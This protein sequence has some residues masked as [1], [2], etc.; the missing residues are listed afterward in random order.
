[1]MACEHSSCQVIKLALAVQTAISLSAL[2][3]VIAAL[4]GDVRIGTVWALHAI[5]PSQLANY[6]EALFVVQKANKVQHSLY[7]TEVPSAPRNP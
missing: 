4:L 7:F 5:R 6:R 3:G 1:M 2:L